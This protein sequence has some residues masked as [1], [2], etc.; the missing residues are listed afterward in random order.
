MVSRRKSWLVLAVVTGLVL[1]GVL[2]YHWRK[3]GLAHSYQAPTNLLAFIWLFGLIMMA[4]TNETFKGNPDKLKTCAVITVYNE[5]PGTFKKMLKSLNKQTQKLD[6]VII[7]DDG[8]QTPDCWNI[9]KAWETTLKSDYI[10]K[11]NAGKREAQAVAFRRYK[12]EVYVTIDSDTVLDEKAVEEG[13]KPFSEP[14]VMS[15]AG[16]LVGL[17]DRTSLLTRLI[18][19]G[20]VLSFLNGR[21]AWSRVHSVAVNCGGLAFYR[22]E[23]IHKHLE[24]YL[25]QTVM[26]KKVT[27]GDDRILTNFA[28]LEGWTIFQETSVGY[29]LL[30]EKMS[31]LIRQRVRWWRSYFWGGVWLIRRFPMDRV[32]WWL[33][34]WQFVSFALFTF[35]IPII[36]LSLPNVKISYILL[37]VAALSYVRAARYLSIKRPD[38]P[39]WEQ[40]I[41]YLLAPLSTVL[42]LVVCTGLQYWGLATFYKTGWGTREVV[43]IVT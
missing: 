31:H 43:E 6:K 5:D 14:K 13:L 36:I 26:G 30:P 9:Y 34:T 12:A 40:L 15:V 2:D 3:L 11:K 18:D 33:V 29:T 1:L 8:S 28:S 17:N 4:Y 24:E 42:N 27:S 7:I 41:T 23:V 39:L 16:L 25:A 32:I 22:G 35:L 20:F 38:Q 37:Y 21:A 10:Y 19:L